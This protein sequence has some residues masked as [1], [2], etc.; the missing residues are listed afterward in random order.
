MDYYPQKKEVKLE[1][2]TTDRKTILKVEWMEDEKEMEL[3]YAIEKKDGKIY[4]GGKEVRIKELNELTSME[5]K[6]YDFAKEKCKA[7]D[8]HALLK[9][10]LTHFYNREDGK[11]PDD[12]KYPYFCED[13]VMY[14]LTDAIVLRVASDKPLCP[15]YIIDKTHWTVNSPSGECHSLP[16]C[17]SELSE[18]DF[19]V[20]LDC[21]SK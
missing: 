19:N 8:A 18:T 3:A 12:E 1:P 17:G 14:E 11:R 13:G 6:Y 21:L 7:D 5:K 9:A 20:I 2:M 16:T 4:F 15:R 10:S